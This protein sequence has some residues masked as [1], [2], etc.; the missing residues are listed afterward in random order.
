M[1]QSSILLSISLLVSGR[2]ETRQCL[3]SLKP[4]M[5]QL[6]CELILVD[7]GCDE[8]TRA[9]IEEYT[10]KI[11]DFTWC[12]DFAKARNAGLEKATGKW[13]LF[14]DD[15]EWFE[16]PAE[17]IEFFKSGEYK[18]YK[19]ASYKVRNY[20]DY[21][22]KNYTDA[23]IS[24]MIELEKNTRFVGKIHEY[25]HPV[26]APVK[27]FDA[28]VKHFGYIYNT[29]EELYRHSKRNI[30][31]LLV[32][33]NEEP[34]E[35]RWDMQILQEYMAINEHE[36]TI[37]TA[38]NAID[39]CYKGKTNN[40]KW[41]MFV[42][43]FYGCLMYAYGRRYNYEKQ[44]ECFKQALQEKRLTRLAQAY[45]YR[46]AVIMYFQ[47]GEYDNCIE[48]FYNYMNIYE[49]I[50][51]NNEAIYQQGA[52]MLQDTFQKMHYEKVLFHGMMAGIKLGKE[53]ILEQCYELIDW[54]DD[55]VVLPPMFLNMFVRYLSEAQF[56]ENHV[57]M[58]KMLME[59]ER[60]KSTTVTI[61]QNI[62]N[63][64]RS[65]E[66][67]IVN[68]EWQE[69]N[70]VGTL[71]EKEK[72]KK[73]FQGMVRV[74]SELEDVHWYIIYLKILRAEEDGNVQSMQQLFEALFEQIA[75]IFNLNRV[76]WKI[77][78]KNKVDLEA[79]FM[80]VEFHAW[81]RAVLQWLRHYDKEDITYKEHLIRSS[82]KTADMRYEFLFL[83]IKEAHLLHC[84]RDNITF[85]E[86][87]ELLFDFAAA[88]YQYCRK[89]YREEAFHNYPEVLPGEYKIA[90]K[91]LDVK[92][93]RLEQNDNQTLECMKE[94]VSAYKPFNDIVKCYAQ[95]FGVYV[96]KKNME[97]D[98][99]R[100]ELLEL[101]TT[102]KIQAKTYMMAGRT[103]EAKAIL[104][105]L[106]QYIPDDIEVKQMLAEIDGIV[107]ND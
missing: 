3:D 39:K 30:D 62:E 53:E 68:E 22:E 74:F 34:Y 103:S 17:I 75:D 106:V 24:R 64:Y 13:F 102:L 1:G 99:A 9:I 90:V 97:T 7:T 80:Q 8:G 15:D 82:K 45:L 35:L 23:S 2:K 105:Q 61:L 83:Q 11:V 86:L 84:D 28:Y 60:F 95:K 54:T 98:K 79:L 66:N 57:S 58:A 67:I 50:G 72:R 59:S 20:R 55:K 77:A 36:K 73:T 65:V 42:G 92:K 27:V 93:A 69:N 104:T 96:K 91:L 81:Q 47:K 46:S 70:T 52:L 38:K 107:P 51:H 16:D 21:G 14:L 85:E 25:L 10:D 19:A 4:F 41:E 26:Y 87:E 18:K 100:Q 5:E 78:E 37:E 44:E 63:E 40:K 89:I 32:M 33:M 49:E 31:L 71:E 94:L 101:A 76:I 12:Q 88:E 43:I 29:A 48:A 6:P 56:K